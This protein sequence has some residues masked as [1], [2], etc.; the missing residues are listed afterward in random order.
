MLTDIYL[1]NKGIMKAKNNWLR[2]DKK[3]QEMINLSLS[4][5]TEDKQQAPL[6][7]QTM[8]QWER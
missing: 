2:D 8:G 4:F 3:N 7:L 6:A 5:E 1:H